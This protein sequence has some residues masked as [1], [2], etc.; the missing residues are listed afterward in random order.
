VCSS[1]LKR[2][3]AEYGRVRWTG[4]N[5]RILFNIYFDGIEECK[6]YFQW[7]NREHYFDIDNF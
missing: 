6:D 4:E 1:D 7:L 2:E 3:L 5:S